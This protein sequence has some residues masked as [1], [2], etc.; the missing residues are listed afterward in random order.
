MNKGFLSMKELTR[1]TLMWTKN[2]QKYN[3]SELIDSL[4]KG[5]KHAFHNLGIHK[6]D[7]GLLKCRGRFHL[8][9]K[10]NP[11]LLPKTDHYSK[12]VIIAAHR[13][14]LHAGASQT[15]AEVRKEYWI[16]QGRSAVRKI[17]RN[18]LICIHW[19]GGPFKTPK[20]APLPEYV[21]FR[22]NMEP[23]MVVGIDYLGPIMVNDGEFKKNWICLFTCLQVRAV[24]LE[25]IDTMSAEGFL[26]CFR[27]FVAR[28]GKPKLV[29]S[30]NGS[31]LKLGNEII[32]NI[33]KNATKDYDVQSYI[34]NEK[35]EWK[36]ITEY[37]P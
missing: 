11:I 32:D 9:G 8:A 25:L 36:Y 12:L 33:W 30:D 18:C 2:V 29:I 13:K 22:N 4:E 16:I 37:A 15:L 27:R 20:M 21:I 6:D 24:Y 10:E 28:R 23:F 35:I 17:I 5:R 1:S 14:L 3:L 26:F 7:E 34:A 19:E 31:Q